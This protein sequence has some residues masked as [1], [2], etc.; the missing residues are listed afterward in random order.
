MPE[1]LL[2]PSNILLYGRE[3]LDLKIIPPKDLADGNAPPSY[4][5]R[6]GGTGVTGDPDPEPESASAGSAR[7]A[8][9]AGRQQFSAE[10]ARRGHARWRGG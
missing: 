1:T 10:P 6:E 8:A 9:A 2:S 5:R 4:E 7:P 3:L